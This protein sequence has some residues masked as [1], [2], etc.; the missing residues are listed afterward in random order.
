VQSCLRNGAARLALPPHVLLA[1]PASP[2][3]AGPRAGRPGGPR[4]DVDA[5]IEIANDTE[6]GLSSATFPGD[7][8][9]EVEPAKRIEAGMTH[10]DDWSVNDE[11]DTALG[12]VKPSGIGR[13]GGHWAIDG[14]IADHRIT[15]QHRRRDHLI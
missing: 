4:G 11:A 14:F 1:A 15:V 12:G 10:V 5:P 7:V 8:E 13:V 9:R 2:P 6:Y 3:P